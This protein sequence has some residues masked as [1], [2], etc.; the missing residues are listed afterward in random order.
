[1]PHCADIPYAFDNV[2]LQDQLTGNTAEAQAI[3]DRLAGAFVAFAATGTPDPAWTP[4]DPARIDTMVFDRRTAMAD[5]PA[6]EA[7]R[8]MA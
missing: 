2:A 8:L 6:G 7:R 4:F 1:V 5:D 3:A